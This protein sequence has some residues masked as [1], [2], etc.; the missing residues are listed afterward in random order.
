LQRQL[1]EPAT[2]VNRTFRG[3]QLDGPVQPGQ[4]V[5]VASI[6]QAPETSLTLE[7]RTWVM[8]DIERW[9]FTPVEEQNRP[10]RSMR[11][12]V[13]AVRGY[14]MVAVLAPG[15]AFRARGARQDVDVFLAQ[16]AITA[17][18]AVPRGRLSH[19]P[20]VRRTRV[21]RAHGE[22]AARTHRSGDV[23][24]VAGR[25]HLHAALRAMEP[26][27][28]DAREPRDGEQVPELGAVSGCCGTHRKHQN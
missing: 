20:Q 28:R 2:P 15:R 27:S 14:G 23:S 6:D 13:A 12:F 17:P 8:Y 7:P 25:P 16:Q 3:E 24:P 4:I 9:S 1:I 21:R 22:R 10:Y 19:R 11:R 18:A 26:T 5:S